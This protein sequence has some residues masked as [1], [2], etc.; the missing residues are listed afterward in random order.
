MTN[1]F[2]ALSH[3][4]IAALAATLGAGPATAICGC[5]QMRIRTTATPQT[6]CSNQDL[7]D[8]QECVKTM[9]HGAGPCA[10]FTYK[11]D[12]PV[13]LTLPNPQVESQ[14]GF[15]AESQL[16]GGSNLAECEQGQALQLT[17]T[18]NHAVDKPVIGYTNPH[19]VIT[20]G[21]TT[22]FVEQHDGVKKY[23]DV[24][25]N[26]PTGRPFYGSD[27][28]SDP[29]SA[30]HL[31]QHSGGVLK[32]WDNTDQEKDDP[33]EQARWQYRFVAFVKGSA[34]QSDCIC[35][36]DIDLDW[37]TAHAHQPTANI[38]GAAG[39]HNCTIQ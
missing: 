39:S 22:F 1:P 30:H 33:A 14:Y 31:I 23:P 16:A 37:R 6:L 13:G 4:G 29:A 12:C 28:Y 25:T 10:A 15:V 8:F 27:N 18:S 9:S 21:G 11:Y 26:D 3:L 34:G 36:F 32:W 38:G 19:G 24:G 5:T 2:R 35:V 20:V 7:N 17:I